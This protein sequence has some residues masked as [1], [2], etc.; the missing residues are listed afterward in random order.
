M[1]SLF[2]SAVLLG[3]VLGWT[4]GQGSVVL[5]SIVATEQAAVWAS[6]LGTITAVIVAL[7]FGIITHRREIRRNKKSDL[8]SLNR[9]A[10][11]SVAFDHEL[12]MAINMAGAVRKQISEAAIRS[13]TDELVA[14]VNEGLEKI[15]IPLLEQFSRSLS[16]FDPNVS[17][18]LLVVLSRYLQMVNNGPVPSG[19]AEPDEFKAR[20]LRNMHRLLDR[21]IG[22]I[23]NARTKIRPYHQRI[24]EIQT[25]AVNLTGIIGGQAPGE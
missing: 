14:Y 15:K 6:A 7:G 10:A 16:D 4:I 11:I 20:A 9:A 19:A 1:I 23:D 24:A 3:S 21:W 17:A 22:D 25:P 5:S 8:E 12:H 18:S 2:I 13:N